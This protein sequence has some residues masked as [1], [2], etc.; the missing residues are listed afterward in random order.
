MPYP[1]GIL[2]RSLQRSPMDLWTFGCSFPQGSSR[3][4]SKGVSKGVLWTYGPKDLKTYGAL[5][6][7]MLYA[8]IFS[9]FSVVSAVFHKIS[10]WPWF[11]NSMASVVVEF[12]IFQ[13]HLFQSSLRDS[14]CVVR[15]LSHGWRPWAICKRPLRGLVPAEVNI[16]FSWVVLFCLYHE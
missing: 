10:N 11:L 5:D 16:L 1:K 2:Q 6:V 15:P 9:V 14:K 7:R 12:K 3:G 13:S 8:P 4:V